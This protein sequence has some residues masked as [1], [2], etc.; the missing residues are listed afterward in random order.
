[1][2]ILIELNANVGRENIFKLII[3]N[4]MLHITIYDNAIRRVNLT[5]SRNLLR[6]AIHYS[7]ISRLFP[8]WKMQIDDTDSIQV[9]LMSDL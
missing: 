9:C 3:G 5:K 4:E 6:E 7:L 1:M 8:D 2:R